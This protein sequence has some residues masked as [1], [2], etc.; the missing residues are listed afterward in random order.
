MKMDEKRQKSP[1]RSSGWMR[2][3]EA[4]GKRHN[5][6]NGPP[7]LAFFIS[8]VLIDGSLSCDD[9]AFARRKVIFEGALRSF[10]S[11]LSLLEGGVVAWRSER[12]LLR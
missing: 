2:T 5:D 12:F 4:D 3:G 8:F 1:S 11:F 6:V 9:I 10:T 7:P